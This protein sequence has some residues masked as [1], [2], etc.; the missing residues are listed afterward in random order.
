VGEP[1]NKIAELLGVHPSSI[2][3][4]L[5]WYRD[6][7]LAGVLARRHGGSGGQTAYLGAEQLE[8]LRARA[9]AGEIRTIHDGVRW[10]EEEHGV[11]YS[12]WGMRHI[13][14]RLGLKKKVARPRSAKASD[15]AQ[16]AWKKGG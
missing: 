13:Y 11:F 16:A 10:A 7:G 6:D 4:W 9:E 3:R 12:Y 15:E 1:L 5:D 14:E 8:T 2:S